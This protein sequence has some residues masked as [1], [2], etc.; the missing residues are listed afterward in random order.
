[1]KYSFAS[2]DPF[3]FER[4]INLMPPSVTIARFLPTVTVGV[5]RVRVGAGVRDPDDDAGVS[6]G[7]PAPPWNV[8]APDPST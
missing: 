5:V 4:W 1:M 8:P 6:A 2:P 3:Q 7:T